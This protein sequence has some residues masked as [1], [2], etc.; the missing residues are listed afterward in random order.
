MALKF[1][2]MGL[3]RIVATM[4]V[5]NGAFAGILQSGVLN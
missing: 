3:R 2:G 1:K 4:K 5:N